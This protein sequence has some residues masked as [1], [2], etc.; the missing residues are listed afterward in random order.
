[1]SIQLVKNAPS[2]S[3]SNILQGL[4]AKQRAA[5]ETIDGPLL[6]IAGAGSGKTKAL[7]HR[8][9]NLIYNGVKPW[10][11]LA[12]T[13]TNKA[14]KEMKERISK[15]VSPDQ[16]SKI[17]AGTFHSIFALILRIESE[18]LG[19]NKSFSIY[20]SDDSLSVIKGI[21]KDMN[22]NTKEL[23]PQ[24]V[25]S[26]IS[27]AKNQMITALE[28]GKS[29]AGPNDKTIAKIYEEYQKR[30]FASNSMDFDDLLLNMIFLFKNNPEIL[31]KYQNK[32]QYIL[33][34]EYQDT[35]KAQY[36]VINML[37]AAHNNLCVVGDD[38]QSIYRWRGA[39][40]RNILEFQRDYPKAKTVLLEQNYRSTKTIIAAADSVI[41]QN[42]GQLP[43]TLWTDNDD[44]EL[45]KLIELESDIDEA[46]RISDLIKSSLN[47]GEFTVK[48]FA[49]LYR[50]N[51]Q[52]LSLEN[53]LRRRKIDYIV[54]GGVSFYARKEIKDV[55]AYLK[56]LANPRDNESL[57]R[58]INEPPRGIGATTLQHF[59]THAQARGISLWDAFNEADS[60]LG[61]QKRALEAINKFK[62]LIA[63]NAFIV[64][65]K[66]PMEAIDNFIKAT[67]ILQMYK[68]VDTD[69]SKDRI[70]NINQL[71]VDL[72]QFFL[73]NPESS[74]E[75]YLQQS[76]LITDL[77][78]KEL[79]D[80]CVKLMTIHAAKGLEFPYVFVA[81]M[82]HGLFP[83]GA[84]D[85]NVE[86]MEEERRLFY[87]AITR[88]EKKLTL[89]RC[90]KRMRYGDVQYQ[91]PS[92]LLKD[93]NPM[94]LDCVSETRP[95]FIK[96]DIG[97]SIPSRD[98]ESLPKKQTSSYSQ[99]PQN[100]FQFDDM[101]AIKKP[102]PKKAPINRSAAAPQNN[103]LK[104]PMF[105]TLKV[106]DNV[107]HD[108]FGP[109]KVEQL[110][111]IADNKQ[112]VINFPN[113]GKKKL[114]LKFAKLEILK[115]Q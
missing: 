53:S 70:N 89:T 35:N 93:I 43:K 84:A 59:K 61:V 26:K 22:V 98:R 1:M 5:V 24:Q 79:G 46:E 32:Y 49:I 7:T 15:I 86:E 74:V 101:P 83:L 20:D 40:I 52:S 55:L 95:K 28:F 16:A 72:D 34:D 4:N 87:V 2:G 30:M 65:A 3:S 23:A 10:S 103:A 102:I 113:I 41:K 47:S 66:I 64:N 71:Y 48:D 42:A 31:S 60:V 115:N 50:T 44:G 9:A 106:G 96:K 21:M 19:Y 77:D 18:K 110:N 114:L 107:L 68:E 6:I 88:A 69:E 99:I 57:L 54:V 92:P 81:G 63:D 13:F 73:N 100:E 108:I 85:R 12:L 82:E 58:A 75:E 80:N 112:A 39:D 51:A 109:G 56:L 11:I 25:R 33:V 104:M 76:S 94:F 67:G 111:G 97:K 90:K 105:L 27:W 62:S 45:I 91:S 8:I 29:V 17:V 37:A 78:K 38:A 36:I 14:A